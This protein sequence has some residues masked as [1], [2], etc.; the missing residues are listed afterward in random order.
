M[1]AGA[2]VEF[3]PAIE[4]GLPRS[5]RSGCRQRDEEGLG[6]GRTKRARAV[7][8]TSAPLAVA[9]TSGAGASRR[10]RGHEIVTGVRRGK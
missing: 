2:C 8:E 9:E 6:E 3:M 7:R 10:S 1:G 5:P 4:A